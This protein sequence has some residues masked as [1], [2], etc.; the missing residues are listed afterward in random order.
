MSVDPRTV[1]TTM[2]VMGLVFTGLA[3]TVWWT[4]RTYPGYGRWTIAGPLLALSL[5]LANLRPTAPDWLSIPGANAVMAFASILYF[6]GARQFRGL[7]PRRGIMYAGGVVAIGVLAFFLYVVPSLNARAAAM[8]AFLAVVLLCSSIT[9]LKGVPPTHRLGLRLTGTMFALSAATNLARAVY[10][11]IGP[12]M[13][14]LFTLAGINGAFFL[15]ISAQLS[16]FSVGFILLADERVIS[17]LQDAKERVRRADA[18][19]AQRRE[20][21]AFLRESERRFRSLADAAPVMIWMSGLDKLCTYFNRPWLDFTGRS[22]EAEIGD[23]WTEDVHPDDMTRCLETYTHAF[24]RRQPFKM[25]YRLRRHD[26]E[27]RSVLNSGVPIVVSDGTFAGYVGS[28][29]DVT[30]LRLA[31]EAL[32][33]LSRK[34]MEAQEA[35]RNWI[36]SELHDD[37][38]QQAAGLTMQ[39][40]CIAQALPSGSPDQVRSQKIYGQAASLTRNIQGVSYRL[41]S[42]GLGFLGIESAT[43]HFC[44]DVSEQQRVQIALSVDSVPEDLPNEVAL[45]LFRVLQESVTNAVKH[46]G[47]RKVEVTLRGT[48]SELQLDVID[49]GVG[50]DPEATIRTQGLGLIS[51]RERLNLVSGEILFES[52][53][54]AGTRVRARVPLHKIE[55]PLTSA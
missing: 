35:E 1:V 42:L 27:Y 53:P 5:F 23:G 34:L 19:V 26:G 52:R 32:S 22:I 17:D 18:E 49:E 3:T 15:G 11:A 10:C 6:E 4:R 51:M 30:D 55:R 50:F 36:A 33:N 2:S 31:N 8:S 21:E 13:S 44:E 16:L 54:G 41:H 25:E 43:A 24:D 28:V 7:P 38:A 9:L 12:R 37:L 40:Y 29:I 14:D 46:S 20:A 39:L 45:A 48:H 47:V